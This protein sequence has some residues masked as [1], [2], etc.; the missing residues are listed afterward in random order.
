MYDT[1]CGIRRIVV[2]IIRFRT[3]RHRAT[4]SCYQKNKKSNPQQGKD[5]P[6][7]HDREFY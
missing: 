6:N 2:V 5:N 4:E 3:A 7:Q 1:Q